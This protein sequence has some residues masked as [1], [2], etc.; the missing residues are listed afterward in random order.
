MRWG[1]GECGGRE[2]EVV[3][4]RDSWRWT[5]ECVGSS[6]QLDQRFVNVVQSND[7]P[8]SWILYCWARRHGQRPHAAT[9]LLRLRMQLAGIRLIKR[10]NVD[11][12]V[13]SLLAC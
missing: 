1:V 7:L 5:V 9:T 13:L 4:I 8:G 10:N 3:R 2:S 6:G 12:S 11:K